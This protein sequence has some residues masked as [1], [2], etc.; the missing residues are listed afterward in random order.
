M[1]LYSIHIPLII[2]WQSKVMSIKCLQYLAKHL[3]GRSNEGQL[4][5]KFPRS[6]LYCTFLWLF[7]NSPTIPWPISNFLTFQV[8]H[9]N[10]HPDYYFHF[11]CFQPTFLVG[12]VPGENLWDFQNGIL[13]ASALLSSSSQNGH[14]VCLRA[15]AQGTNDKWSV[16]Y[17]TVPN[18]LGSHT[19]CKIKGQWTTTMWHAAVMVTTLDLW[20]KDSRFNSPPFHFHAVMGMCL[21]TS[22]QLAA[23]GIIPIFFI[24]SSHRAYPIRNYN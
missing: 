12:W 24:Y 3:P 7:I 14:G 6:N 1:P 11:L 5:S 16:T 4:I 20:P 10:G 13:W 19:T 22:H 2:V 21:R 23:C 9:S 15:W 18:M 8:F 17:G